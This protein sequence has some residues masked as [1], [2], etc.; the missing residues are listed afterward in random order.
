MIVGTLETVQSQIAQTP[1]IQ[2]AL[3]YLH[4]FDPGRV[5]DGRYTVL[6]SAVFAIVQSY[7]T[8]PCDDT[9]E[10]EG[11]RNYIDIYWMVS[12]NEQVGWVPLNRLSDLPAYDDQKDAWAKVVKASVLSYVTLERGD[13]AV[14]FPE[15][16][17]AAQMAVDDAMPAR[18]VI[19]KVA[20][21]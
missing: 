7:D 12:G 9:I 15:D 3:A 5:E 13:A 2:A 8:V 1:N 14:L 4:Q 6:G 10:I 18:K 16:A 20:I 11:H 19:M 21:D 17:H